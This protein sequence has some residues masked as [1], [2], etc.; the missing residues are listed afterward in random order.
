MQFDYQNESAETRSE[1]PDNAEGNENRV[2]LYFLSGAFAEDQPE[3]QKFKVACQ[4]LRSAGI[5]VPFWL[6]QLVKFYLLHRKQ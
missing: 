2:A 4:R 5:K 3:N 6:L 1:Q